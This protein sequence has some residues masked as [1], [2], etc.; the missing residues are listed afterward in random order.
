MLKL[1]DTNEAPRKPTLV[2][3]IADSVRNGSARAQ[4]QKH[5]EALCAEFAKELEAGE[6]TR[7]HMKLIVE[8]DTGVA[9]I[10]LT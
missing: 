2:E 5:L 8:E 1:V 10:N 7:E 3:A 6:I 4:A 9:S